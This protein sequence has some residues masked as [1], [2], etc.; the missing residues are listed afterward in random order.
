MTLILTA[1]SPQRVVQVSDR[2]LTFLDGRTYHD[3]ANKAVIVYCDDGHFSVAYTGLAQVHDKDKK[4][5]TRTDQW[6]ARSLWSIMQRPGRWGSKEL[7]E[8]FQAH[9]TETFEGTGHVPLTRKA[10]AFVF[11]G[12]FYW[13]TPEGD[14]VGT[15]IAGSLSNMM[16]TSG[17][18][19]KVDREFATLRTWAARSTMRTNDIEIWADGQVA[20]IASRDALAKAFN[21]RTRI[22]HRRLQR[23]EHGAPQRSGGE[24][25]RE[26]VSVIRMASRHPQYGKYIGR[27][28]TVTAL[29]WG[30]DGFLA[31]THK[32]N[33]IEHNFPYIVSRDMVMAASWSLTPEEGSDATAAHR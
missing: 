30:E 7:Y 6:I 15:P 29:Q 22:L 10:T 32:E 1:L 23:V 2:K 3:D 27:D 18:G 20:A 5:L 8:A 14:E 19:I 13:R 16:V 21:R 26:L 28:C 4:V 24:V 25:A 11:A 12:F 33:S 17:G 31:D 9:A